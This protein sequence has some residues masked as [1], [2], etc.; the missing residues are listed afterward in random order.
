MGLLGSFTIRYLPSFWAIT[1]SR[2]HLIEEIVR[3][4]NKSL[5]DCLIIESPT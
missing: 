1:K 5:K 3:N 4:T 2:T